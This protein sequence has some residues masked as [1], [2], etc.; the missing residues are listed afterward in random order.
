VSVLE[1]KVEDVRRKERNEED[2]RHVSDKMV[3]KNKNI[4]CAVIIFSPETVPF[5]RQCGK[6]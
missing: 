4:L 5:V 3:E 2:M 1:D 6:F